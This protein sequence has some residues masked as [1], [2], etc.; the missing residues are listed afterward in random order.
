MS[1]L[2]SSLT[3]A[4][5]GL[6]ASFLMVRFQN[7]TTHRSNHIPKHREPDPHADSTVELA[8]SA[9]GQKLPPDEERLVGSAIHY[10]FGATMG[11][12]YGAAAAHDPRI[13][14]GFGLAYGSAIFLAA[15]ELMLPALGLSRLWQKPARQHI[16]GLFSHWIYGAATEGI[17]RALAGAP[18]QDREADALLLPLDR[19]QA[20]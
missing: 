5:A 16:F 17:Y 3:G 19:D 10:A 20:A 15:D 13:R 2:R 14:S 6:C 8:E 18:D 7:A 1:T 4:F 11:A 12:L 9:A